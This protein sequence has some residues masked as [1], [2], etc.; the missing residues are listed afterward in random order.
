MSAG[1]SPC[2]RRSAFQFFT[3]FAW[4]R[5][6]SIED[7]MGFVDASVRARVPPMPSRLMVM[8]SSSPSRKELAASG[9]SRSSLRASSWRAARASMG[10]G[11]AHAAVSL[12]RTQPFSEAGR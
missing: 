6:M 4:A 7:S 8:V 3:F 1:R 2:E 11:S 10:S 12:R 9:L 5:T